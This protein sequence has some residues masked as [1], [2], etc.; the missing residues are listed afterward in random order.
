MQQR[1]AGDVVICKTLWHFLQPDSY[2]QR[3]VELEHRVASICDAIT[4]AGAPF[5]AVAAA[6]C[7]GN[8]RNAVRARDAIRTAISG[9]KLS[10]RRQIG[11]LLEARGWMP[12]RRT[13]K[14]KQPKI[15]D[16][17]L[18]TIPASYPEFAGLAEYMIL[19]RWLA[20]LT[21]GK[22]AWR[23]NI[24]VDGRIH[25]GVVHIGT[26]H[27]RAKHLDPNLAEVPNPKK[28]SPF[29]NE[30]RALFR[31]DNGWTAS[32][33]TKPG[34]KTAALPITCTI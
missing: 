15:D 27:S 7:T 33:Q 2:S 30:C 14:T 22:M 6:V 32:P 1:C 9:T 23:K 26:P 8:G 31:P 18:E 21:T 34:C 4:A 29:G 12:E 10:S 5:D 16:E 17:L 20:A 11:A 28:G 24:G 19:G 13:E 3:A 25:G